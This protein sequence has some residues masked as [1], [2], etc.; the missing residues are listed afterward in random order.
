MTNDGTNP[1]KDS[2][3]PNLERVRSFFARNPASNGGMVSSEEEEGKPTKW[4]MGVL[5]DPHTYE[6]PGTIPIML[7]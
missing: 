5:N 3:T 4:S 7:K 2:S 1:E 6:V